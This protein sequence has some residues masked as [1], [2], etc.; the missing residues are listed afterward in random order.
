[1]I[2]E[3]PFD[4]GTVHLSVTRLAPGL[5]VSDVGADGTVSAVAAVVAS[6][7]TC[8]VAAIIGADRL[9]SVVEATVVTDV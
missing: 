2:A 3:Q 4:A 9:D 5:A 7:T 1:V 8:A 6:G